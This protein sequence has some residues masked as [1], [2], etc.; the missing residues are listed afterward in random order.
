MCVSG[1]LWAAF[2]HGARTDLNWNSVFRELRPLDSRSG[3]L[4]GLSRH[5]ARRGVLDPS[6]GFSLLGSGAS[7]CSQCVSDSP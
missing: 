3:P 6:E 2:L 4:G 5:V 1:G 7:L